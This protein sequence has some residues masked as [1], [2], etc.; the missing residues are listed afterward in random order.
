MSIFFKPTMINNSCQC[1]Y[2]YLSREDDFTINK[3]AQAATEDVVKKKGLL[4]CSELGLGKFAVTI[5]EEY[6]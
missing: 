6:L 4:C 1:E 3:K 2:D 5:L